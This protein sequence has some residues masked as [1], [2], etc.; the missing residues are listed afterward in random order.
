MVTINTTNL[1]ANEFIERVKRTGNFPTDAELARYMGMTRAAIN[2][3]RNKNKISAN[4]IR[5]LASRGFRTT[6]LLENTGSAFQADGLANNNEVLERL[7]IFHETTQSHDRKK[8]AVGLDINIISTDLKT[9]PYYISLIEC[10]DDSL[11]PEIK[12]GDTLIVDK[13]EGSEL[14]SQN[15]YCFNMLNTMIAR[16]VIPSIHGLKLFGN[17]S[18]DLVRTDNIK[19]LDVIGKVVGILRLGT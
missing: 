17:D 15:I 6:W 2:F 18:E 3:A 7:S 10:I 13:R 11:A 4:W 16:K 19:N 12:K 8:R 5:N 9:T 14:V 1:D